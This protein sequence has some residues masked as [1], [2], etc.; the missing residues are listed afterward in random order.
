MY[1]FVFN[2]NYIMNPFASHHHCH[3]NSFG[4]PFQLLMMTSMFSNMYRY[5]F[6]PQPMLNNYYSATNIFQQNNYIQNI[7]YNNFPPIQ[8]NFAPVPNTYPPANLETPDISS[9]IQ[10][11][12]AQDRT[13]NT[14]HPNS[15]PARH[16]NTRTSNAAGAAT[17]RPSSA[18]TRIVDTGRLDRNF[19]NKVKQVAQNL[20]CDYK[21]LLA[22]MNSESGLNK[23][24]R[25][26][27]GAVGLIQFTDSSIAELRRVYGINVTKEQILNMSAIQQLDLV[28]K[29]LTIAK[30]YSFPANAR[31]S[32]GDLYSIV[33]LPGRA[34]RDILCSR[35]EGNSYYENNAPLDLNHDGKITKNELAQRVN[36]KRVNESIFA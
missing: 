33:F 15:R 17:V 24:A 22:V 7:Y 10:T 36:S 14:R 9:E 25:N 29:Y 18:Q 23:N 35:G 32:A 26:P 4:N 16:S 5:N 21:D 1:Q 12:I 19:L 6:V 31:L 30:R 13:S 2:N 3:C 8:A 20:N 27:L 28:E 11:I 34:N